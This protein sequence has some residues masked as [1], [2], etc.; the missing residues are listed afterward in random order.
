MDGLHHALED[1][2]EQLSRLLGVA[3]GQQLHRGLQVGEQHR[4]LLTLP[5]QGAPGGED[6]LD[7]VL[8]CVGLGR[9]GVAWDLRG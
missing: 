5:L 1:R 9:G 6:L 3:V 7:E 2:V 8:G 4:H